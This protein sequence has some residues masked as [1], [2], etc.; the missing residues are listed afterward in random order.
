MNKEGN[1]MLHE[2]HLKTSEFKRQD[3]FNI[4][5]DIYRKILYVDNLWHFFYEDEQGD[6]IRC[7]PKFSIKV[8]DFLSINEI[9]FTFSREWIET[10]P[11]VIHHPL[12]FAN[13]FHLN[14]VFAIDMV[15]NADVEVR[16]ELV[17]V[18]DRYSHS[19][20]L[21]LYFATGDTRYLWEASTLSDASLNRAF[22]DGIRSQYLKQRQVAEDG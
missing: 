10:I 15:K 19:L 9:D 17:S 11:E 12:Y 2:F 14:S 22:Y 3:R 8:S 20:H 16:K 13:L 18:V 5:L 4:I 21:N 6:I 7:S 1:G